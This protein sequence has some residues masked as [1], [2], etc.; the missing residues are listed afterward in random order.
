MNGLLVAS[1]YRLINEIGDGTFGEVWLAKRVGTNEKVA[2]K[3]MKRKF[4]SWDEAMNLREVKSLRK[5][6][7]VNVVKLKEVIREN[8]TLYFVFE[9]MKENLYEMAK[10]RETPFP[11]PIIC[12]M[13]AQIL[14]G[15]AY[16]HKHGFFHRD[17]KPENVLCLG[18]EQVKIAD[19]GLAREVRSIPP[20]TD[21][22]STRW[23]RAPEV[24]LRSRNYSSPI[25]L[26][27]VGCIMAELYLMRPLFPGSSEIDE[28][29]KICAI[30]GTPSRDE[31]P[32][33]Y[34]LAAAMNFRFPQCVAVPLEK[35]IVGASHDVIILLQQ[36]LSWNPESRPAATQALKNPCFRGASK[37]I[38]SVRL[39]RKRHSSDNKLALSQRLSR[40]STIDSPQEQ[41]GDQVREVPT[42]KSLLESSD[43]RRPSLGARKEVPNMPSEKAAELK[44]TARLK[45]TGRNEF[46]I[47]ALLKNGVVDGRRDG[48]LSE[49][50]KKVPLANCSLATSI[51]H[52][53]DQRKPSLP[54]IDSVFTKNAVS[55]S[56]RGGE[57]W[58][59]VNLSSLPELNLSN[60]F[61]PKKDTSQK[62]LF[63]HAKLGSITGQKAFSS[64]QYFQNGG[65]RLLHNA[66]LVLNSSSLLGTHT[67]RQ[68]FLD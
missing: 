5:L 6:N 13:T 64:R 37:A 4:F 28:I 30:L 32:K 18:P 8:D 50:V 3:R 42:Y 11:Q 40:L 39:D 15:L 61:S 66:E 55:S 60:L 49:F 45:G 52:R 25:D 68:T 47:E 33:G 44:A 23:Y 20:Y 12:L 35:L 9:Y 31:W 22:V 58:N 56:L 14:R 36:L 16:I 26:W 17:M 21:Y 24:L 2:V 46:S 59:G 19:F 53:T 27:A 41:P 67:S 1:R 57:N 34:Q 43:Q 38:D 48:E 51:Q 63:N 65:E 62:H 29:F 54:R 10:K 7:H